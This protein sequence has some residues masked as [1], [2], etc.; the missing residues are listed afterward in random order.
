MVIVIGSV[1]FAYS[2]NVVEP[3]ISPLGSRPFGESDVLIYCCLYYTR[4]IMAL[5]QTFHK[6]EK[7]CML[8]K[9]KSG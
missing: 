8:Y 4:K 2:V 6:T 3:L 7:F 5:K 9:G 1:V